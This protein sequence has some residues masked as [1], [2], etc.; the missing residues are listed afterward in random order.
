MQNARKNGTKRVNLEVEGS[1]VGGDVVEVGEV[2]VEARDRG[3]RTLR[4]KNKG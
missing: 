4:A 1:E 2:A 3:N